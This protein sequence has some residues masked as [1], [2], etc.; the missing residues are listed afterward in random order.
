MQC[1]LQVQEVRRAGG[2]EPAGIPLRGAEGPHRGGA[3][4]PQELPLR[5]G[6]RT[7]KYRNAQKGLP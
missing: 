4:P 1:S 6:Q 7:G 3:E 5:Q 2:D